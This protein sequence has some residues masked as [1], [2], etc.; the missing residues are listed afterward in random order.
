MIE[1]TH[2]ALAQGSL[3]ITCHRS[4]GEVGTFGGVFKVQSVG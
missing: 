3:V 1:E 2:L 4:S